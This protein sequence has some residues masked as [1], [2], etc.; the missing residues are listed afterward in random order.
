MYTTIPEEQNLEQIE[1]HVKKNSEEWCC[2]FA[3]TNAKKNKIETC[4][5]GTMN[6]AFIN[7]PV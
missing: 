1:K 7:T 5:F 6:L 2:M 4:N 3:V